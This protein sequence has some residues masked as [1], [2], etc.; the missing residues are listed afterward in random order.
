MAGVANC[1]TEQ[2]QRGLQ[3]STLNCYRSAISADHP[4]MEGYKMGQHPLIKQ[5]MQGAFNR[6]PPKPRY[7]DTWDVESVLAFIKRY[8]EVMQSSV[9]KN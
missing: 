2:L 4:E 3:Y 1:L 6:N 7:S 5:L 8:W 9:A